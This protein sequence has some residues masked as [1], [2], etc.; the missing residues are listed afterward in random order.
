MNELERRR[1]RL[2]AQQSDYER[3]IQQAVGFVGAAFRAFDTPYVSLS[4]GKD[5]T[6]LH[7][8]V[9]QRCGYDTVDIFHFDWGLRDVPGIDVHVESLVSQFGGTLVS[10]TSAKV[11]D[12]ARFA[13]DEHH[14]IAG[15]LGWVSHLEEER[16]WDAGLL[17]IRAE[18]SASRAARYTGSPPTHHNGSHPTVAP[19]HQLTTAD[20]WAYIVVNDLPY[21]SLYDKQGALFDGIDSPENRLVT[22]YDHEFASLGSEAIS[23]FCYPEATNEL[24]EIE[25][26]DGYQ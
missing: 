15:L 18:E 21:H 26:D 22:I 4:G 1:F 9:T 6:V 12:E 13:N 19:I 7:H 16:G 2:H 20:V 25:Q 5:S 11:N 24:K 10:R 14:G 23:Q 17:G 3:R 8:L